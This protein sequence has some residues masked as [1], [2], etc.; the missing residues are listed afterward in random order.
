MSKKDKMADGSP[1]RDYVPHS[2]AV[3]PIVEGR[4]WIVSKQINL[5]DFKKKNFL[6]WN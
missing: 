3:G 6:A 4:G 1:R 5:T 2:P